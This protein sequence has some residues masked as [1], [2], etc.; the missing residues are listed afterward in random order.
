MLVIHVLLHSTLR[1][2]PVL[3][4]VT[5]DQWAPGGGLAGQWSRPRPGAQSIVAL[6]V[7]GRHA[8]GGRAAGDIRAMGGNTGVTRLHRRKT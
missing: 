5:R 1:L 6:Q 3:A 8:A 4:M 7:Q 2:R